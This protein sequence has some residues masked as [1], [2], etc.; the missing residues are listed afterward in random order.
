MGLLPRAME[1]RTED[2]HSSSEYEELI[3]AHWMLVR[4]EK[5]SIKHLNPKT[6]VWGFSGENLVRAVAHKDTHTY[7]QG[8]IQFPKRGCL[9]PL[10][11]PQGFGGVCTGMASMMQNLLGKQPG[12]SRA[13]QVASSNCV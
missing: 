2:L 13:S 10:E 5:H 6:Q 11:M 8:S 7:M 9:Q 3:D 12:H 1:D 4:S